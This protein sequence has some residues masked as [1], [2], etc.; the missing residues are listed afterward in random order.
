MTQVVVDAERRGELPPK[1]VSPAHLE[2]PEQPT[3]AELKA[4][5]NLHRLSRALAEAFCQRDI[6]YP[7]NQDCGFSYEERRLPP[8]SPDRVDEWLARVSQTVFRVLIVGAALAGTYWE[9]ILAAH[10]HP[11][12]ENR[13]SAAPGGTDGAKVLHFVLTFAA[14]GLEAPLEAQDALFAPLAGWLLAD[15]LADHQGR[16]AM[17]AR[18]EKGVGRAK[19]CQSRDDAWPCPLTTVVDVDGSS[20]SDAHLVVWALMKVFWVV[21]QIRPWDSPEPAAVTRERPYAYTYQPP[22]SR[23]SP[24]PA[25]V[26]Q[27]G[28]SRPS[29]SSTTEPAPPLAVAV[30]FGLWRAESV[31]L[32]TC[33]AFTGDWDTLHAH[34]VVSDPVKENN[35][36]QLFLESSFFHRERTNHFEWSCPVAPLELKFFEYCLRRQL[37]LCFAIRAFRQ[38]P[39]DLMDKECQVFIDCITIFSHDDVE[40]REFGV[41]KDGDFVDGSGMLEAWPPQSGRFYQS[42]RLEF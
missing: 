14:Y 21:E 42:E 7:S 26:S 27:S 10:A 3:L 19:F 23:N 12:P 36:V 1:G 9:P 4:A 30:F 18:F 6:P 25:V 24:E 31:A 35:P 16:D 22:P 41:V 39:G 34:P 32:P 40:G 8:E 17:A 38:G 37:N 11:D 20:H 28:A 33:P 5:F 29:S 2:G 13:V 15:I